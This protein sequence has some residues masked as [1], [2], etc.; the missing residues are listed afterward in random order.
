MQT[1][2][3]TG[4]AGY[5]GSHVCKALNSYGFTPV[6]VDNLK[7]GSK[8]AVKY[9]PFI[10][11]NI[12][13]RVQIDT[14][15]KQYR[16]AAVV[17]LAALTS[18]EESV[19]KPNAYQK[20]NFEGTRNIV[21]VMLEHNCRNIVFSSTCAV[22]GSATNNMVTESSPVNP[23]SPYAESKLAAEKLLEDHANL[24]NLSSTVFRYFNVAGADPEGEIGELKRHPTNL[25]PVI[26]ECAAGERSEFEIFGTDYPTPDGTCIRDYVHVCDVA[27]AHVRGLKALLQGNSGDLFNIG[28][29]KGNSV[30]DVVGVVKDITS[31]DFAVRKSPRRAGDVIQIVSDCA[32]VAKIL[33]WR[34]KYSA[35]TDMINDAWNWRRKGGF[36]Q[37]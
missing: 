11:A 9:G 25:I 19:A 30:Q 18:V 4:G 37:I 6:A 5:V 15:F 8:K 10:E 1:V 17:H 16:P 24:D 32:K 27:D 26:L 31:V 21:E 33:K 29:G 7:T 36:N 14:A 20:C 13:N 3:V 22:Y 12:M 34:P 2:I 28:T 35:L 23:E